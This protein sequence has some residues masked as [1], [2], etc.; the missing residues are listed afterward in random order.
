MNTA[1]IGLG[2]NLGEREQTISSAIRD[3]Q[4][5]SHSEIMVG[6]WY[7]S[8]P[9]DGSDQPSYINTV[10]KIQTDL[11]S[12]ELLTSLLSI[13]KAHGRM[14]HPNLRWQARTLD[15]DLLLL[16][17][18]IETRDHLTVPHPELLNRLFVLLPLLDL[19][20]DLVHPITQRKLM[21]YVTEL[22]SIHPLPRSLKVTV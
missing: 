8:A 16:G 7:E 4:L 15:L 13:E 2:A 1:F 11:S 3:L 22:S 9:I 21:T 10:A 18:L 14:R 5:L 6:G 12:I 20:P 17:E 19:E